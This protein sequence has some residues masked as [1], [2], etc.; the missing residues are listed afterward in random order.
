MSQVSSTNYRPPSTDWARSHP[1]STD[2]AKYHCHQV[3]DLEDNETDVR[4]CKDINVH[5]VTAY[6]NSMANED[7]LF[8]LCLLVAII[9]FIYAMYHL[10]F[11][12]R[13]SKTASIAGGYRSMRPPLY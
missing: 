6:F 13:T 2:W 3:D 7:F 4:K 10:F 5:F 8:Y 1:P 9:V 11:K 12:T